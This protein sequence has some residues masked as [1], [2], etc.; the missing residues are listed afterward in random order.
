M[1]IALIHP[2][3]C[4]S[5]FKVKKMGT[6][7]DK[8]NPRPAWMARQ[9]VQWLQV[10]FCQFAVNWLS[11][12]FSWGWV[13]GILFWQVSFWGQVH[14]QNWAKM[15]IG[16]PA[17]ICRSWG[18]EVFPWWL[19]KSA[20]FGAGSN[21]NG[22]SYELMQWCWRNGISGCLRSDEHHTLTTGEDGSKFCCF[23]WFFHRISKETQK[24]T[25]GGLPLGCC[26]S[27]CLE[28]KSIGS[29]RER[30]FPDSLISAL[31][32]LL[33][34]S[35]SSNQRKKSAKIDVP[36]L[37]QGNIEQRRDFSFGKISVSVGKIAVSIGSLNGSFEKDLVF[38]QNWW[39]RLQVQ[40]AVSSQSCQTRW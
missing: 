26:C 9:K 24:N 4:G 8:K 29:L 7:T 37:E 38:D 20:S 16:S 10:G 3:A 34:D 36:S 19:G 6:N 1:V 18:F 21:R 40:S 39:P 23:L 22:P 13:G 30:L 31:W 17:G 27:V 28:W 12:Q 5:H 11:F 32:A 14:P 15:A 2:S 33:I 35:S 25:S